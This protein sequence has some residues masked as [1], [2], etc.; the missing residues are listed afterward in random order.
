VG[1][2]YEV[3]GGGRGGTTYR[4]E[5]GTDITLGDRLTRHFTTGMAT[6]RTA[7]QNRE[8][9]LMYTYEAARS[10][11]E[12]GKNVFLLLPGSPNFDYLV[13]LLQRQDVRVEALSAATTL[14]ATRLDRDATESRTF[15]AGTA[16][17]ST[18]QPFGRL[19]NTLLEKS[20]TLDKTFL[21][22][23]RLKAEAD[24]PDEFYDLTTWSLPLAMNVEAY[25][26]QTPV[27]GTAELRKATPPPFRN[28]SYGY[29]IDGLDPSVY[30]LAGQLLENKVNFSIIDSDAPAGDRTFSRGSLVVLK[31][32]N[33]A[34]LDATLERLVNATGV[35][36]VPLESGWVGGLSFGSERVH[37]VKDPKIGLVGGPGVAATSYGMLWHTLDVDTPIPHETLS[38]DS[39]ANLDLSQYRVLVLPDGNYATR[40]GKR[41]VEKIKTWV[42]DGG[43]I[44]AIGG[45]NAFLREKDVEISKLKPWE[46]P[47]KKD[48]DKSPADDRYNDFRIPG[49]AFRTT[50]N[51]RSYLTFGVPRPPAVLVEGSNA[52]LPVAH[53]VDNILTIDAKD[54]LISGVAWP[55]SLARIKGSVYVVNEPFGRGQVVTFAD[56]PHYR[57]FW[58]GTLPVFLNAV[59]YGPTFER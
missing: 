27:T 51:A 35:A 5:D 13:N 56:E 42:N 21:E 58:R 40:L 48:D 23:Q 11:V 10:Q 37:H 39:L 9:L 22:S 54:P 34:T 55:E 3:A 1:M 53:Q 44:V 19:A 29:V 16:V 8:A 24:E 46:A 28:A 41:G 47:K 52:Y 15:P 50:M 20:G 36:V 18:R 30:R 43:T 59:L 45:A 17:V 32:N 49:A 7:A 14:R 31:G 6:V 26:T 12:G 4:R 57:L 33:P 38:L 2:T 25:V